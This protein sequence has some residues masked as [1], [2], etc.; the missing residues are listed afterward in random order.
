LYGVAYKTLTQAQEGIWTKC[1]NA[2]EVSL[3]EL[4]CLSTMEQCV[5]FQ[6][7]QCEYV[8]LF[9]MSGLTDEFGLAGY[10]SDPENG[11]HKNFAY[12]Y[13][14]LTPSFFHPLTVS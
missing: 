2:A 6:D 4:A 8:C 14:L 5:T 1:C 13:D 12:L 3:C 11:W 9:M 7:I 10:T